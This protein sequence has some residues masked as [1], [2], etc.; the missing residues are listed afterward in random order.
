MVLGLPDREI[1]LIRLLFG[2]ADAQSEEYIGQDDHHRKESDEP[3][4]WDQAVATDRPQ[5]EE[6]RNAAEH[7]QQPSG[8]EA[9]LVFG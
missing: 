5:Y 2:R 4:V 3:E 9:L 7:H 8:L 1:A 6:R